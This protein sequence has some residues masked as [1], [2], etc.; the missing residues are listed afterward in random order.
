MRMFGGE[1][2]FTYVREDSPG[3]DALSKTLRRAEEAS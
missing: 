3:G 2:P 1:R